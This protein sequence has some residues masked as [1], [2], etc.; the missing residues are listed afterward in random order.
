MAFFAETIFTLTAPA[1]PANTWFK[2]IQGDFALP[3]NY[4]LQFHVRDWNWAAVISMLPNGWH[5]L[6]G[7]DHEGTPFAF[8]YDV[9]RSAYVPAIQIDKTAP[10]EAEVSIAFRQMHFGDSASRIWRSVSLWMN[11]QNILSHAEQSPNDGMSDTSG[12]IKE[13]MHFGFAARSGASAEYSNVRIPE[14]T[15]FTDWISLDPGEAGIGGL[16]RSIEGYYLKFFIRH[17]GELRAWQPKA[18]DSKYTYLQEQIE[19]RSQVTDLRE[20]RTHVRQVGAYTQAEYM[21]EDLVRK[22]GHRFIELNNPYLM[23]EEECRRQAEL[24]IKR[25]EEAMII[26]TITSSYHPLLELEDHVTTPSGERI[27]SSRSITFEGPQAVE[28]ITARQYTYGS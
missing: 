1:S 7:V 12:L 20:L 16:Q 18:S 11:D 10:R 13:D 24:A 19:E 3:D 5:Y 15:I 25:M 6:V 9:T 27:I 2:V 21:R 26:E 8:T 22:Y 23:T 4:L 17:N 14:L 28:Q